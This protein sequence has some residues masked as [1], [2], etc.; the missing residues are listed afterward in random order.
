MVTICAIL[1]VIEYL[2]LHTQFQGHR[3][4]SYAEEDFNDFYYIGVVTKLIM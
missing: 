3:S 2:V 4:I 1:V